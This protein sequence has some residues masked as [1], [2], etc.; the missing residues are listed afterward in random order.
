MI[1]NILGLYAAFVVIMALHE[2]VLAPGRWT[3]SWNHLLPSMKPS[4]PS[5][6]YAPLLLDLAIFV[7]VMVFETTNAIFQY[8]GIVAW[9]HFIAFLI[10][11]S[12]ISSDKPKKA[13]FPKIGSG[14][15]WIAI[16]V[17]IVA[18]L[19]T[20]DYFITLITSMI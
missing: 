18:F 2:L 16:P 6:S 3:L 4:T 20:K 7:S 10:L 13:I 12:L 15:A 5:D 1:I 17:A 11:G 19:L 9:A 14:D 8:L